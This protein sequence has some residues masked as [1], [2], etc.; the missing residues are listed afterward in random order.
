MQHSPLVVWLLSVFVSVCQWCR[1]LYKSY[2]SHFWSLSCD[3]CQGALSFSLTLHFSSSVRLYTSW[4]RSW[5]EKFVKYQ[6]KQ[7]PPLLNFQWNNQYLISIFFLFWIP[8][9][10]SFSAESQS[11][12]PVWKLSINLSQCHDLNLRA[13]T[14]SKLESKNNCGR[15]IWLFP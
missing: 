4:K 15:F 1:F 9:W 2:F 11:L 10:R 3:V 13:F 14:W 7:N 12:F 8:T 6:I 5:R